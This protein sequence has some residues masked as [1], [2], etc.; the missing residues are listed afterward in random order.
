MSNFTAT[1]LT[2]LSNVINTTP[3]VRPPQSPGRPPP[4]IGNYG[5]QYADVIVSCVFYI[6]I[7]FMA[8]FGNGLVVGSFIRHQ[9]LRTSTNYFV[10]SLS[11]ADMLVGL[12]SV[13]MWLTV[14]LH[15]MGDQVFQIVYRSL[16][17]FAGVASILHLMVI[18]LERYYA[19]GFPVR[20]R[21]ASTNTYIIL[22]VVVWV[23]P[24][25]IAGTTDYSINNWGK[26]QNILFLFIVFFLFPLIVILLTYAGIWI[27]AR[28]RIQPSRSARPLKRDMRIA[29]TIALVIGF[30]LIAWLPFFVVQLVIVFCGFPNCPSAFNPRLVLFLKFMHYSNSAVNPVIYAVKIPEFRRAFRQLVAICLCCWNRLRAREEL[31]LFSATDM[32]GSEQKSPVVSPPLTPKS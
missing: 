13:S 7:A 15:S 23:V 2:P 8:V 17:I 22:L 20:H 26:K 14:L 4:L 1:P 9:R 18:S 19:V 10:V 5:Y 31:E 16:D 3:A 25:L 30:F 27:V 11:V 24:A 28:N 12:S 29:F 21:N 6:I 32:R